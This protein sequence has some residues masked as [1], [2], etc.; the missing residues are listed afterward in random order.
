MKLSG[1][2]QGANQSL[3]GSLTLLNRSGHAC[4]L[5]ALP[6]RVSLQ[7]GRHLLPALTV[8]LGRALWPPGA[9]TRTLPAR[10]G[11]I[12]GI[13]WRNWCGRPRGD[14]HLKVGLTIYRSDTRRISVGLVRTPVCVKRKLSSRVAVSGFVTPVP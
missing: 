14:I 13:Q 7:V 1:S 3:L 8:Q 6:R 10:G 12:V 5:P 11:V 2:L 4:K 9:T